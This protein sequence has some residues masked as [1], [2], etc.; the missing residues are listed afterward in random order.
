MSASRKIPANMTV[1]EFLEWCPE[2]G[3]RW[4][5]VDGT[6]RAV[7]PAKIAHGQLQTEV[8][9]LLR[10]HLLNHGSACSV[11]TAPGVVPRVHASHNMR[12]PD[13]GVTCSPSSANDTHL[14]APVLLVEILSP[15]NQA[16]TWA[17]VWAYTTIPS[18]REILV[19]HS[20]AI[21]AEILRRGPDGNWPAEPESVT[22]GELRLDS[23][24][25]R[26]P[27][28]ALYR[29]TPLAR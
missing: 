5:L 23:L 29:T 15:S 17:N 13:L 8:G 14:V 3:Q 25:Y 21:R 20:L 26:A 18:V 2:D 28:A 16:D 19:L 10:N 12:V 27:I 11:V 7:A 6:P 9:A 22:E 4:E 1:A 24:D